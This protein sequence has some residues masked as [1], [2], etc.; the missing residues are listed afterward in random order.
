[1]LAWKADYFVCE[2]CDI[3][4][5][6]YVTLVGSHGPGKSYMSKHPKKSM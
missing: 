1:M 5:G 6:F 3:N 4:Q 2:Q